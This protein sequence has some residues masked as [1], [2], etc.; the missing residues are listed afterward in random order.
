MNHRPAL[1]P[2]ALCALLAACGAE[3]PAPAQP[4]AASTASV[5]TA[6]PGVP[7]AASAEPAEAADACAL[8]DGIDIDALL[9]EPA[10]PAHATG[11]QCNI[12]PVDAASPASL[13]LQYLPDKG[14]ANYAQQNA[15]FGIDAEVTGLGDEAIVT[16][17]RVHARSGDRF[18][19]LQVVRNP[20]SP[21]SQVKPDEVVE[22]SRRI[23]GNAGW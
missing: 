2:L 14:A 10:A 4:A 16:G 21:M 22:T 17:T 19:R 8:L 6:S 11:T 3:A 13:M 9:G 7:P 18:L 12:R 5:P 15:L 23:A 1:L 20:A